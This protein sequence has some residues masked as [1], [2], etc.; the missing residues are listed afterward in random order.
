MDRIA[1]K[2][3]LQ[4]R[5]IFF[6][7]FE[8]FLVWPPPLIFL[9]FLKN[10]FP[11]YYLIGW[12]WSQSSLFTLVQRRLAVPAPNFSAGAASSPR[13]SA[14]RQRISP[15]RSLALTSAATATATA[16]RRRSAVPLLSRSKQGAS[17]N[18]RRPSP[19]VRCSN[20]SRFLEAV[21][22]PAAAQVLDSAF[23]FA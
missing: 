17:G 15:H 16:R 11:F 1:D 10:N 23:S 5:I 4:G 22:T 21:S 9:F 7:I 2:M 8:K 12:F 13:L 20:W 14:P 18:P 3:I 6:Y 19:P